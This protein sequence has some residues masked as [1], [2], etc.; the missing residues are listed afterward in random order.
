[1]FNWLKN[2]IK[3]AELATEDIATTPITPTVIEAPK[4]KH[5]FNTINWPVRAMT[6]TESYL[7]HCYQNDI[8]VDAAEMDRLNK[9]R[10]IEELEATLVNIDSDAVTAQITSYKDPQEILEMINQRIEHRAELQAKLDLLKA[11]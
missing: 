9:K 1:M 3:G 8:E 6:E 10:E 11:K 4:Q 2:I 5:Q 7:L